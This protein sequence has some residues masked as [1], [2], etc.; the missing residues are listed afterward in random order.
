MT[1]RLGQYIKKMRL[2]HGD[3]LESLSKEFGV[4]KQF[5]SQVEKERKKMPVEWRD[6]L[7]E[8][9]KLSDEEIAELDMA[10]AINNELIKINLEGMNEDKMGLAIKFARILPDLTVEQEEQLGLVLG[11]KF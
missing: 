4:S 8:I 3:T 7:I 9:Y 6:K 1:E 10:I 2:K 11:L 5:V